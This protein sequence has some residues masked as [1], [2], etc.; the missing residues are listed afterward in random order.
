MLLIKMSISLI[1]LKKNLYFI[2]GE[3]NVLLPINLV[4]IFHKMSNIE[5]SFPE[6]KEK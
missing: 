2:Y 3:N 6:I 5:I 4:R 1:F